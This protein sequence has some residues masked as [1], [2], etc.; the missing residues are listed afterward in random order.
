[1][2]RRSNYTLEEK[3]NAVLDS[4]NGKRRTSQICNDLGV[5]KSV[6]YKWKRIYDKHGELGLLQKPRNRKY[7]KEFKEEVVLT[8]LNGYK[9][10][11][12]LS[13]IYDIPSPSTLNNWLK[14]YN[15]H[16]ELK[17]YDPQGDIYMT[18]PRKTTVSERIEVVTYCI[19]LDMNYKLAAKEYN[20]SY[21]QVYQ[22]TKKYL[23]HG[24]EGL[25]DKRGQHKHEEEVDETE[26]L[27]KKV[28]RLEKQL[29]MKEME[30]KLLKK[31]KEVERRPYSPKGNKK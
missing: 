6:L 2:G 31:V 9:S 24:E 23:D 15:S 20:V 7:S 4:K 3:M 21:G 1:M 11:N 26:L 13:I 16:I 17:D 22:W 18:K 29:E 19:N 25:I 30:N 28:S 14:K 27:R 12:D 5:D 8:Y 10:Y